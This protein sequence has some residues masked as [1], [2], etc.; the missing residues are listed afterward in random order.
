VGD[1]EALQQ[2]PDRAYARLRHAQV[3]LA[4]GQ[5][6]AALQWLQPLHGAPLYAEAR[7]LSAATR[8]AA[9]TALGQVDTSANAA[10]DALLL[11]APPLPALPA[12]Q[13]LWQRRRAARLAGDTSSA[14]LW[15]RR[16]RAAWQNLHGSL[17][18]HPAARAAFAA[19]WGP[20]AAGD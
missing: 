16:L 11:G 9:H 17:A 12:L 15:Q 10:A 2:P 6:E 3:A 4:A 5:A 14:A 8:L 13:L 20:H 19:L 18:A 1:I 7:V